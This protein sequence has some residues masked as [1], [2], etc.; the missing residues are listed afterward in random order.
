MVACV[1]D[2]FYKITSEALLVA[3]QLVRVLRP[4]GQSAPAGGF[5]PTQFV[6]QVGGVSGRLLVF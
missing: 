3:Q 1:D 6:Q 5:K 2:S 4:Q